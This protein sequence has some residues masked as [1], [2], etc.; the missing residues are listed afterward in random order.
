VDYFENM[1]L[2]IHAGHEQEEEHSMTDEIENDLKLVFQERPWAHQNAGNQESHTDDLAQSPSDEV[3]RAYLRTIT[4]AHRD[5][6]RQDSG[7][8][9]RPK[10]ATS[11]PRPPLSHLSRLPNTELWWLRSAIGSSGV[12]S[13][14]SITQEKSDQAIFSPLFQSFAHGSHGI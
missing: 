13:F 7:P 10:R 14:S 6:S 3:T 4:E 12:T 8:F 5:G 11:S 9:P 1:S 2:L